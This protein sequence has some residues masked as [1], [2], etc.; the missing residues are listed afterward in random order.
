MTSFYCAKCGVAADNMLCSQC[1]VS[2]EKS[3]VSMGFNHEANTRSIGSK[4]KQR[5]TRTSY[6]DCT[7]SFK[8]KT[9]YE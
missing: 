8:V 6:T 7:Y 4:G 3:S 2:R 1:S 9:N 5:S